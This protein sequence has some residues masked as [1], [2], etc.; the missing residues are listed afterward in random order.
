[1]SVEGA[2]EKLVMP[3]VTLE[4]E[5]GVKWKRNGKSIPSEGRE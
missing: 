1:M 2:L 4:R 3:E 5:K